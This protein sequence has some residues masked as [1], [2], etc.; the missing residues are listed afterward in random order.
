MI[1]KNEFLVRD[2]ENCLLRLQR[3]R[4]MVTHTGK[5]L[6]FLLTTKWKP[7]A[8]WKI[9]KELH[10]ILRRQQVNFLKWNIKVTNPPQDLLR[11][12]PASPS[13]PP[14]TRNIDNIGIIVY[15]PL[16]RIL[17]SPRNLFSSFFFRRKESQMLN[18]WSRLQW[19]I[20]IEETLFRC[21]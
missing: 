10:W 20:N 7:K 13:R 8:M 16:R 14:R 21:S 17:C 12:S 6:T 5:S 19:S 9:H 15:Y 1:W 4:D 18:L 2:V 11:T 3:L